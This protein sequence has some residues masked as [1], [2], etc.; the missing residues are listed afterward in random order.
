VLSGDQVAVGRSSGDSNTGGTATGGDGSI[1]GRRLLTWPQ[2]NPKPTPAPTKPPPSTTTTNNI[3]CNNGQV[4]VKDA[5]GSAT[6]GTYAEG[7]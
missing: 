1:T 4:L 3:A 7:E 2:P 6:C 5:S